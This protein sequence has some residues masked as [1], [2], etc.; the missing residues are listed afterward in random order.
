MTLVQIKIEISFIR[1]TVDPLITVCLD[2]EILLHG[3]QSEAR[4]CLSIQRHLGLGDHRIEIKYHNMHK[5]RPQD[6]DMAVVIDSVR[7][8]NLDHDFSIYSRYQPCYPEIWLQQQTAVGNTCAR[9]IHSN[10]LGWNG[11][12]FLDFQVPIYSWAHQKMGLGWLL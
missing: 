3:P 7:M 11:T 12:W 9:E 2:D 5:P 4:Q 8:Q 10:Y 1:A 6:P